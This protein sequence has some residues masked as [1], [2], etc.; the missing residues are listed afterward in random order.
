[1]ITITVS[2]NPNGTITVRQTGLDDATIG[3]CQEQKET[4]AERFGIA[5]LNIA[6]DLI[7]EGQATGDVEDGPIIFTKPIPTACFARVCGTE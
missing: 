4:P 5:L 2:D 6:H 7:N 3:R 1:M